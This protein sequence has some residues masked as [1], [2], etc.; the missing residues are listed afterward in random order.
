[1]LIWY[2]STSQVIWEKELT[3]EA[4]DI[5]I[6]I[7]GLI[8]WTIFF[9]QF[10]LPVQ[11]IRDRLAILD[12]MMAY[13]TGFHGPAIFVENGN[14]RARQDETK[15]RGPGVIWLDHA[16]A[17]VLRT[18]T[19][20]TKTVG[21]GVHFTRWDEYVAATVDLHTLTQNIGPN[22]NENPFIVKKDDENYQRIQDSGLETRGMTRDGIQVIAPIAITFRIAA[23]TGEGETIYGY[24]KENIAKVVTES[25]VQ[26]AKTDQPIWS[27]MPGKMAAD[28]WR[29]YIFFISKQSILHLQL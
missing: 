22:D 13:F 9:S 6:F 2:F 10:I 24:N 25:M 12:R 1:M 28:I 7:V 16:S 27:P 11:K 3:S 15:K 23:E 8:F 29:E 18:A 14:I 26:G 20:F 19:R 21:P 4:W 17:A 5:G